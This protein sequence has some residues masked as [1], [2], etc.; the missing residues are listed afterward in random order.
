M[1]TISINTAGN[2]INVNGRAYHAGRFEQIE[3][4]G[5]GKW[6]GKASGFD[7]TI[8]GGLAAGGARNEWFVKWETQGVQ[9][10]VKCGSAIEA[11]NFVNNQ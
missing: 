5:S 4:T 8:F 9:D 10:F 6:Q 1:T 11:I 2:R 7:F 3:K